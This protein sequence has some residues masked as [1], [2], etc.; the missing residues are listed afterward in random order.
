MKFSF[1]VS[2][3]KAEGLRQ[4]KKDED[5]F[6]E[7]TSDEH[8]VGKFH[9]APEFLRDNEFIH[10]GYRI[11]FNSTWKIFK[12]LFVLHNE[13][14]NVWTH[15]LGAIFVVLLILYTSMYITSHK[16]ELIEAFDN[17]WANLNEDYLAPFK[18][19]TSDIGKSFEE[20][21]DFLHDYAGKIKNK[22][23]D[24]L[25]TIDEKLVEYKVYINEKI[26]Y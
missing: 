16:S 20:G 3:E 18:N 26:K 22:T 2:D 21:K 9:E 4:L 12:S 14:V 19:F 10:S 11:N 13:F 5:N 24:Y 7:E 17:K 1:E 8:F 25:Q 23:V 15:I 6:S